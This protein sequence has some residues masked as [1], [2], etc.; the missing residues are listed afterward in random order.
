[1]GIVNNEFLRLIEDMKKYK[2]DCTVCPFQ[3]AGVNVSDFMVVIGE[4]IKKQQTENEEILKRFVEQ[5]KSDICE[6]DYTIDIK[7]KTVP[8]GLL[9]DQVDWVLGDV[10]INIID[11]CYQQLKQAE[12]ANND[13]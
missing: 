11:A 12:E 5:L 3:L 2:S 13:R 10:V 4:V 9:K 7:R 6:F 8:V 1:M